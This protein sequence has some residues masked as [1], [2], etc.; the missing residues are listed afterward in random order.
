MIDP[1]SESDVRNYVISYFEEEGWETAST[2]E[3][4]FQ[5]D[6]VM[7]KGNRKYVI[8][9]KGETKGGETHNI[10]VVIG[11]I[12]ARMREGEKHTNYGIAIPFPYARFL[13]KFGLKGWKA[14]NLHLFIVNWIGW[15]WH[16]TPEK[17]AVYVKELEKEK[18]DPWLLMSQP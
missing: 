4:L 3:S 2:Q 1:L 16:L 18:D 10:C 15:V 13:S 12:V 6:I 11:Q 17:V 5:R 9:A 7:V 8:E 14:L